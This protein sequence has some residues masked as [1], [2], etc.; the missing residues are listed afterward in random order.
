MRVLGVSLAATALLGFS[1]L[2]WRLGF[3]HTDWAGIALAPMFLVLFV[4]TWSLSLSVWRAEAGIVLQPDPV[5]AL[6]LTG[7]IGAA[8]PDERTRFGHSHATLTRRSQYRKRSIEP[9]IER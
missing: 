7:E 2:A 1:L 5:L 9:D 6:Y 4:G 8:W 3:D